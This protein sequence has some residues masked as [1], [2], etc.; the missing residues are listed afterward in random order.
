VTGSYHREHSADWTTVR[1]EFEAEAEARFIALGFGA[2]V[3][4]VEPKELRQWVQT[5][6]RA[7]ATQGISHST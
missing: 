3:E 6:A 5:E 4:V 7:M 2:S 1:V